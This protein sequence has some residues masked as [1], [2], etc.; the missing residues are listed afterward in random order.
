[1]ISTRTRTLLNHLIVKLGM[2]LLFLLTPIFSVAAQTP[3]VTATPA[4]YLGLR[5]RL[6]ANGILVGEV[7]ANSPATVA[8]FQVNDLITA[9][10]STPIPPQTGLTTLLGRYKAGDTLIFSVTRN[11]SPILIT[12]TLG[13]SIPTPIP[14]PTAILGGVSFT[15]G[16]AYLG[17]GVVETSG[18][19][20]VEQVVPGSPAGRVGIQVGDIL[21]QLDDQAVTTNGQIPAFLSSK[22]PAQTIRV[23]VS[24][25][26]TPL[27]FTVILGSAS[28]A[29]QPTPTP[30]P[31]PTR[32]TPTPDLPSGTRIPLGVTYES[33]TGTVTGARIITV[34]PGGLAD[35]SGV[36][37][38][39]VITT[40]EGDKVDA[41]RTLS[42]RL[43]PYVVGDTITITVIRN[44]E[45]INLVITFS[46]R[47][48]A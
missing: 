2:V 28:Q 10:N 29:A 3:T 31:L 27:T 4:P 7:V 8:G 22:A 42:L 43:L 15:P 5:T 32:P 40:V 30:A 21:L 18:G 46:N 33:V 9:I 12:A 35:R 23:R 16:D 26:G 41:K 45:T 6:E 14:T 13:V 25:N 38:G 1:M 44:G 48:V 19:L 11:G 17:I 47:E 39:D 24:R 20:R 34:T 36:Q 37:V